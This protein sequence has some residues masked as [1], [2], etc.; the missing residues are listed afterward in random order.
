M[1]TDAVLVIG[2]GGGIG[3]A[4]TE[5]LV[6]SG[7]RVFCVS[8]RPCS[9]SSG[10]MLLPEQNDS[11]IARCCQTML[12][13]GWRFKWVICHIGVLYESTMMPEKRLEDLQAQHLQRYFEVNSIL[14]ALWLKHLVGLFEPHQDARLAFL[15]ARVGSIEDNRFGGWY[16]YRAS[17]AALNMLV[18]TAQVEYARRVPGVQLMC[19]HPGTVDT[20]LSRPFK[21]GAPRD[22]R[23]SAHQAAQYLLS[24][25]Q[26]PRQQREAIFIDWQ[27]HPIHW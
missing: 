6:E 8:R 9:A 18:K 13:Q 2:A 17:K 1:D 16:G 26:K 14:P 12:E 22:Q 20:P 27:G 25:L 3:S 10:S 7:K 5:L 23:L 24:E 15:S 4:L 19:Y 21:G 11:T